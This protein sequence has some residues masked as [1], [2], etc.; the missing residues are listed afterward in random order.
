MND[1][2]GTNVVEGIVFNLPLLKEERLSVE[3][4]SRMTK[5]KILKIGTI[6]VIRNFFEVY[7]MLRTMKWLGDP[8]KSLST[9]ELRIMEL[10]GYPLGN[11][12]TN[13]KLNNLIKLSMR[14][15]RIT[16]LW[17][18]TKSLSNLKGIDLR[19]SGHLIEI[20]DLSGAPNLER[21]NLEGCKNLTKV[22]PDIGIHKRLKEL[23]L[24]NCKSLESLPEEINLESV[25]VINL[26]FIRL[27]KF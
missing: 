26:Y 8:L 5:L 2:S 3:G 18:G 16:K 11:L 7:D 9:S 19:W 23:T 22:Y 12:L 1:Q 10:C 14:Y 6:S 13:L 21:L 4:F 27:T 20:P 15:S 25:K 24:S 17:E